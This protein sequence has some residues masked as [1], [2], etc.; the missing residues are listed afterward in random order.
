ML[1]IA[2]FDH[3]FIFAVLIFYGFLYVLYS[4][5]GNYLYG[6]APS[7]MTQTAPPTPTG[8]V[9]LDLLTGA[10]TF[11]TTIFGFFTMLFINPFS[12]SSLAIFGFINWAIM[13]TSIYL[14]IKT[15]RGN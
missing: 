13:G 1:K 10:S 14:L 2:G 11:F 3:Q 15:I 6:I 12:S 4:M 8:N 7:N 9:L 5:N